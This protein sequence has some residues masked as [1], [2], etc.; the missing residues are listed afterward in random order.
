M[1][2]NRVIIFFLL[3]VA[4]VLF[5]K[6][7]YFGG[8][9]KVANIN[10]NT[11][12]EDTNLSDDATNIIS[13]ASYSGYNG[14]GNY[15]HITSEIAFT[16][17]DDPSI[18]Q[19]KRVLATIRLNNLRLIEIQADEGIFYKKTSD[20][21]FFGNVI[22]NEQ[23]NEIISDNLNLFLSKNLITAFNNVHY[24]NSKTKSFVLADKVVYDMISNVGKI[25][26][27]NPNDKVKVKY[28]N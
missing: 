17:L 6:T 7:Y 22:V 13:N 11:L 8:K 16:S 27:Y 4:I 24:S 10:K 26:M 18:T 12:F 15:Y 9:N 3:T 1:K 19:L 2:K 14:N 23:N 25:F 28:K 21:E 20:A 5:V